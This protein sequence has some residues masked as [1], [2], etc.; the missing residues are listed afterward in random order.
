MYY[1]VALG[2]PGAE[3]AETRHN[4]GRMVLARFLERQRFPE[5]VL[6]A[7]YA[8]LVSE[9]CVG[10]EDVLA[11]MPET[12]MNK[13]GGA[14]AK[15]VTSAKQAEHLVVVYDDIDLP[16]GTFRLAFGRGS[17]GHRGVESV[18]R[19]LK[20]KRFARLRV[21][22]APTTPSGTLKKPRGE[23]AVVDF[24]MRPFT[25]KEQET[26]DALVPQ[27]AEALVLAVTDGVQTAM[28]RYN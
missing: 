11:L 17:G 19:S 8:A 23:A 4:A 28:N 16:L 26:L 15:A 3:Y 27:M 7:K 22:V 25:K 13:S 6:S 24:L 5:P 1:L 14:V 20:T 2:N 12:Y 10:G 9:G 18:T 21:G